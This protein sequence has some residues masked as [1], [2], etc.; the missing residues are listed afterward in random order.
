ML[1]A[2]TAIV[3]SVV[4]FSFFCVALSCFCR[5]ATCFFK[6]LN[7]AVVGPAALACVA[8]T[9]NTMA[10]RAN[11]I[12]FFMPCSSSDEMEGRQRSLTCLM[13]VL[14][15]P[16][17]YDFELSTARYR[18]WGQD[19]ANLWEDGALWRAVNGV[20]VRIRAADGGVAVE[21]FDDEIGGVVRKLLGAE[22]DLDAFYSFAATE[23]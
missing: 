14:E 5:E 16:E 17:P 2:P 3:R 6:A 8:G 22:F 19:L 13:A 20:A 23:P 7:C 18:N 1:Y 9:A 15:F 21:P 11:A 4:S 12:A 10:A